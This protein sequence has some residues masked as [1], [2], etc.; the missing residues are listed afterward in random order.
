MVT[1][2]S[3]AG[4]PNRFLMRAVETREWLFSVSENIRVYSRSTANDTPIGLTS[5]DWHRQ[6]SRRHRR[7]RCPEQQLTSWSTAARRRTCFVG[8]II[9]VI[10]CISI[11][12]PRPATSRARM[13]LCL[14]R[15]SVS[16]HEASCNFGS[17]NYMSVYEKELSCTQFSFTFSR[18]IYGVAGTSEIPNTVMQNLGRRQSYTFLN[19]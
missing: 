13:A 1:R 9:P 11:R 8:D 4:I 10:T 17:W 7:P 5:L 18:S 15:F 3:P 12:V 14:I 6:F 16:M 2:A 19:R